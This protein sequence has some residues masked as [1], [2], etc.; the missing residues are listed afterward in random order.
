[1]KAFWNKICRIFDD[2]S[3]KKIMTKENET[4]KTEAYQVAP[5]S[6][7]NAIEELR[8]EQ[9]DLSSTD[10]AIVIRYTLNGKAMTKRVPMTEINE[11]YGV[12]MKEHGR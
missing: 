11:A 7:K 1:M 4:D 9:K 10:E 2:V 12:A 6:V 5:D 8:T 3:K